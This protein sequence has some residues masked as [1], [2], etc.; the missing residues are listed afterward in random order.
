MDKH[1]LVTVSEHASVLYGLRFVERFFTDKG[2]LRLTLFY[3]APRPPAL[4]EEKRTHETSGEIE[5]QARQIEARGQKALTSAKG[6]LVRMGF[7][8]NQIDTKL[9]VRFRSKVADIIREAEE[10]LYDALVLGRRGLS[11]L[12][13]AFDDSTS[14]GILQEKITFPLWLCRRPAGEGRG[15]LVCVD[16]SEAAYRMVDHVGFVAARDTAQE[17]T[18]LQVVGPAAGREREEAAV[19]DRCREHLRRNGFPLERTRRRVVTSSDVTRSI[20]REAEEGR[21]AAVAAG[22][23]G[24]GRGFLRRVFMGSVSDTLFRKLDKAALW[25]CQ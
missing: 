14:H 1:L 16:G 2:G 24:T 21:F 3:T 11:L 10:G 9:R 19:M 17:V 23:T 4:F 12:E 13:E 20:L 5:R 18:L 8:E 7:S 15:I 25:I 22:R 6:L